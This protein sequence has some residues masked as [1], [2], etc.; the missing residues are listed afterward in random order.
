MALPKAQR[1]NRLKNINQWHIRAKTHWEKIA[2]LSA[3]ILFHWVQELT[4]VKVYQ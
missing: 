4:E 1:R 3:D 2:W